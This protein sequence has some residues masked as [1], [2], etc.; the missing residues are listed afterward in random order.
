[1]TNCG[2]CD[3]SCC[4][5]IEVT[6]GSFYRTYTNSG[7]GP[8]GEGD[9]ASVSGLR[10][11]KYL[12][13]VGRF[14]QFVRAWQG[15][16]VP[17]V[18]SGKHTHLNGGQGLAAAGV[19]GTY[20]PGWVSTGDSWLNLTDANLACV[21]PA[22][23]SPTWT[24]APGSQENLP[25]NCVDWWEAY[26]FCIWDGAFLPSEAELGY[27]EAGGSEQRQ[28]PWGTIAPGTE[29]RYAIFG[30]DQNMD[31]HYPS[32]GGACSGVANLA[33]VGAASAGA[34]RWSQLDLAGDVGEWALDWF[35][36]PYIDPCA[37]CGDFSEASLRTIR[38]GAYYLGASDL[39]PWFRDG[40]YP[41]GRNGDVGF[42]CART[43]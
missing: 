12:V 27:V 40:R 37:D 23:N 34:G 35:A 2:P 19:P 5:S 43:P 13:T 3:E 39:A 31:C 24:D 30:Y 41:P 33:A 28:Y 10:I 18:G 14:R 1:M 36:M 7:E 25:I 15:G 17:E 16:Y 38:G 8:T 21:G 4:R 29:N 32:P 6:G 11:D 9:L 20:E 42:R 26:A 22:F